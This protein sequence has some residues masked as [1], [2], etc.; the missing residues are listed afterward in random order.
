MH[1]SD[2]LPP[3]RTPTILARQSR[4]LAESDTE[5]ISDVIFGVTAIRNYGTVLI[6]LVAMYSFVRLPFEYRGPLDY[7][8]IGVWSKR[9]LTAKGIVYRNRIFRFVGYGFAWWLGWGVILA[10]LYVFFPD[11]F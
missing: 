8:A 11:A 5:M 7:F 6:W 10:G 2:A 9:Y 3:L 1:S 4:L